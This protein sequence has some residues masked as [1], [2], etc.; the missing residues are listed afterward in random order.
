MYTYTQVYT[1]T[2]VYQNVFVFSLNQNFM[3]EKVQ[4]PKN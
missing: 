3:K 4:D 1:Y 2:C